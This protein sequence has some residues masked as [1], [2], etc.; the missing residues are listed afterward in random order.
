MQNFAKRRANRREPLKSG[1][2]LVASC[3]LIQR[4]VRLLILLAKLVRELI[5]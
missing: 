2:G 3:E 4:L 1:R 5:R